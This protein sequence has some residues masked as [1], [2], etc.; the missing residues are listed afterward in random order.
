VNEAP[1]GTPAAAGL[2]A[3]LMVSV[4]AAAVVVVVVVVAA[5]ADLAAV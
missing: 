1:K 4:A 5:V 2:S 3:P